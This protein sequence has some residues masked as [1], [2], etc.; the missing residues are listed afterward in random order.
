MLCNVLFEAYRMHQNA[1]L[2]L[3]LP[4]LRGSLITALP[5]LTL[6]LNRGEAGK[7]KI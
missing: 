3:V 7:G 2:G 1:F 6:C 4:A 5:L